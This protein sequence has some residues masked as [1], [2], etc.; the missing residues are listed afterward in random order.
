MKDNFTDAEMLYTKTAARHEHL[1]PRQVLG[2]R[3]GLHAAQ[4]FQILL[5]QNDKRLFTII[6]TDGCFADGIAVATGCELGRRTL[7]L[8]D[9][10]KIAATFIDTHTKQAIRVIPHPESRASA[11][12]HCAALLSPWHR[13]LEAYQQLPDE[14]LFSMT[15]VTLSFSLDSLISKPSLKV[16]CELCGEEIINGR[17]VLRNGSHLCRACASTAYYLQSEY[18]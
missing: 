7:R 10:G 17:E 18:H 3:M 2:V 16:N 4:H 1:C 12:T 9:Y 13:Y 15:E 11:Q 5:P 6:E 14:V 8:M